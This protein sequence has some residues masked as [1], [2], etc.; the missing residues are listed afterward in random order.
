MTQT[1][2]CSKRFPASAQKCFRCIGKFSSTELKSSTVKLYK[3]QYESA[4]TEA[5]L[6]RFGRINEIS[7]KK[8]PSV[9]FVV[10]AFELHTRTVPREMKNILRPIVPSR[11]ISSL[12]RYTSNLSRVTRA[13]TN[14]GSAFWK[15]GTEDNLVLNQ[16]IESNLNQP[17]RG[18][19]D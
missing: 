3:Q 18:N 16:K 5:T 9:K 17:T 12:K 15:N 1:F 19:Y 10:G 7:P 6:R 8:D 14:S 4:Q 2:I 11:I 13:E